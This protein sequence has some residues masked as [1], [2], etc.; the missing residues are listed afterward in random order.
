MSQNNAAVISRC[1]SC[2]VTVQNIQPLGFNASWHNLHHCEKHIVMTALQC[3]M[4]SRLLLSLNS[5]SA[6]KAT[7]TL[8]RLEVLTRCLVAWYAPLSNRP[9]CGAMWNSGRISLLRHRV[10]QRRVGFRIEKN[11]FTVRFIERSYS[12]EL[13]WSAGG[14]GTRRT[15]WKRPPATNNVVGCRHRFVWRDTEKPEELKW[16]CL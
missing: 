14:A 9:M 7:E 1:P 16:K 12:W 11:P 2:Q 3:I 15:E 10:I 6:L 4:I 5:M 13:T 8:C